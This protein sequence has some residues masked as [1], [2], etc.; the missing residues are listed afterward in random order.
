[1]R[2]HWKRITLIALGVLVALVLWPLVG[3]AP[4]E[5]N[6]ALCQDALL[7]RRQAGASGYYYDAQV[8]EMCRQY[9]FISLSQPQP[10]PVRARSTAP[11][12]TPR[13]TGGTPLLDF[14]LRQ[15]QEASR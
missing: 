8:A 9:P 3:Q 14:A 13:P 6:P 11:S 1:M 7:R 12:G 15:L 2:K 5:H 10:Q 4:W